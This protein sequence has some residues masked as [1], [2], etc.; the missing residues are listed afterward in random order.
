MYKKAVLCSLLF[1]CS[2][3]FSCTDDEPEGL[4]VMK[5]E[6]S[7]DAIPN[8]EQKWICITDAAGN[9]LDEH[10]L[11]NGRSFELKNSFVPEY[12]DVTIYTLITEGQSMH[13][14]N[15]YKDIKSLKQIIFKPLQVGPGLPEKPWLGRATFLINN[16]PTTSDV[17]SAVDFNV[18][19][20]DFFGQPDGSATLTDNTYKQICNLYSNPAK[21]LITTFRD[22]E[23]VYYWADVKPDDEVVLDLSDFKLY[24]HLIATS[25]P[26]TTGWTRGHYNDGS[27]FYVDPPSLSDLQTQETVGY[28]GGFDYYTTLVSSRTNER[29]YNYW[30]HGDRIDVLNFPDYTGIVTDKSITG[31]QYSESE[32]YTDGRALWALPNHV[33]NWTIHFAESSQATVNFIPAQVAARVP[34]LTLA[35]MKL[36]QF[37][38]YKRFDGVT[39]PDIFDQ[40]VGT[41]EVNKFYDF[42]EVYLEVN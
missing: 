26:I 33:L 39:F 24:D 36:S 7:A 16:F 20:V 10:Q 21:V 42:L 19:M 30:K 35:N 5:V 38:I 37:L 29:N 27:S 40:H 22:G 13:L 41:K 31:F 34:D 25:F 1:M 18:N 2:I 12:V 11:I 8:N 28:I 4:T 3:T 17:Y 9:I 15:T 6:V 23:R 32:P 14:I